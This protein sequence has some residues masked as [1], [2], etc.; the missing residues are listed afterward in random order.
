MLVRGGVTRAIFQMPLVIAF[1]LR[2]VRNLEE[3][4]PPPKENPSDPPASGGT[5]G[6]LADSPPPQRNPLHGVCSG[7]I[8]TLQVPCQRH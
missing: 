8:R 5:P 7:E 4:P 1:V 2:S 3:Q 6:A